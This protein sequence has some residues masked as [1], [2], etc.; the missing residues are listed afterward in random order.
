M[1][2]R[3]GNAANAGERSGKAPER[4][5][6]GIADKSLSGHECFFPVVSGLPECVT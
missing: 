4:R 5:A 1:S 2:A 3:K 6:Y